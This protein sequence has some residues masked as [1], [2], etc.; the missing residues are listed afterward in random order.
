MKVHLS[1][2]GAVVGDLSLNF[3]TM[4]LTAEARPSR[5]IDTV[6]RSGSDIG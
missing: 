6:I 5:L 1:R 3:D 2:G 4:Q